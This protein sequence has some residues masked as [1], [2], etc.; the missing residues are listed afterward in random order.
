MDARTTLTK[1]TYWIFAIAAALAAFALPRSARADAFSD[2]HL[3][4][5]FSLPASAGPFDNLPD[6]RLVVLVGTTVLIEASSGSHSFT[7]LG[8]LSAA[9]IPDFGAA[10]LR[11]SP[12]GSKIAIGNNGGVGFDN[13]QVGV[14]AVPSLSGTWFSANHFDGEWIDDRYL[15]LTGGSFG[16]PSIVTELDTQSP[17]P[18]SPSNP[19]L[20]NNI[21]GASAGIS[22]DASHNLFTG[23][24]FTSTGPSGTGLIKAVPFAAWQAAPVNGPVNFETQAIPIV[25]LLS[26]SP[27]AFDSAGDLLVGGGDFTRND[28]DYAAVV[29][30]SAIASAM[31]GGGVIDASDPTKVRRLDPDP[32]ASSTYTVMFNSG[33]NETY[34]VSFG[35]S[36]VNVYSPAAINAPAMPVWALSMLAVALV[37]IGWRRVSRTALSEACGRATRSWAERTD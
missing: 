7:T 6:G 10:F 2:Y 28:L 23:N 33:R 8:T 25:D 3:T 22:F 29:R 1:T 36:T 4:G 34:L 32:A 15:A 31:A 30:A 21:G 9:D 24:G 11:V 27:I 14:F 35:S 19:V 37:G 17:Q 26:A 12:N 16:A 13:F 20:V 5:T 18:S